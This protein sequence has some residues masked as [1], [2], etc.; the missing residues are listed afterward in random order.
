MLDNHKSRQYRNIVGKNVILGIQA[1][2]FPEN[3]Q[4]KFQEQ[5][6]QQEYGCVFSFEGYKLLRTIETK[7]EF[8]LV[9]KSW[10]LNV[11]YDDMPIDEVYKAVVSH[12]RFIIMGIDSF[13]SCLFDLAN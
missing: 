5:K 8:Q 4:P 13:P 3:W 7:K 1:S 6:R 2:H 12:Y 9:M 11:I 10:G